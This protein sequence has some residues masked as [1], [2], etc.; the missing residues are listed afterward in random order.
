M[1]VFEYLD[2]RFRF[3]EII[4][5]FKIP[6]ERKYGTFENLIWFKMHSQRRNR[7]C[8]GMQEAQLLCDMIIN[9]IRK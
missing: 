2:C 7:F 9:S 4:R 1:N 8:E 5:N 6:P 3:E